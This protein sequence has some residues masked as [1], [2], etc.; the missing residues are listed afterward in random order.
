VFCVN[1]VTYKC[2]TL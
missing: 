1:V 2:D